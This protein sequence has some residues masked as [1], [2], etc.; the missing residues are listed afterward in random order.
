MYTDIIITILKNQKI[1]EK[2]QYIYKTLL[3]LPPSLFQ[4]REKHSYSIHSSIS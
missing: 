4:G 2:K 1:S 3:I